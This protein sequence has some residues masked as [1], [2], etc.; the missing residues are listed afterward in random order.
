[1]RKLP[2]WVQK[3]K[4]KGTEVK[5]GRPP[6]YLYKVSSVWDPSKKRS[7]KISGKYLGAITPHGFIKPKYER[8]LDGLK[9]ISVKEFGA[10]CITKYLCADI[11]DLLK[12]HFPDDWNEIAVFSMIRLFYSS[13]M[14]NVIH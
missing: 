1:M 3:Y 5:G 6:Y 14:N 4:T 8:V 9:N 13:P 12:K 2:D 7:R 11:I 10:T